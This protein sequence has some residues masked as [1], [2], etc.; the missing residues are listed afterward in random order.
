MFAWT[1]LNIPAGLSEPGGGGEADFGRY[2]N[3][4]YIF[5]LEGEDYAQHNFPSFPPGFTD[6]PYGSA[7]Y[8]Q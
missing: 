5:E 7:T 6:L 3:L 1:Q 2:I 8:A 4:T